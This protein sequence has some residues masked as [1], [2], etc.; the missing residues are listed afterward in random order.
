[1][2]KNIEYNEAKNATV[3][4]LLDG[5]KHKYEDGDQVMIKE[6][7]GMR[8]KSDEE[9]SING[10]IFTIKV[11]NPQSFSFD[12]EDLRQYTPYEGNGIA[13]QIK[14]PQQIE[15]KTIKEMEEG[16]L[17]GEEA[18]LDANLIISDFEKLP[19]KLAAHRIYKGLL[20]ATQ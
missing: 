9:Q 11:I 8:T 6:V 14:V 3:V 5:F 2:I 12:E 4:T 19:N 16:E 15:F 13:K 20:L 10:K 1:M 17:N 7:K 18:L